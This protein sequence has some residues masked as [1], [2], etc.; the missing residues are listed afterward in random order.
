MRRCGH[1]IAR[2]DSSIVRSPTLFVRHVVF[3]EPHGEKFS[4]RDLDIRRS[5]DF[6][7]PSAFIKLA[8][9]CFRRACACADRA[10]VDF[11]GP[12][13]VICSR[14]GVSGVGRGM[15][16]GLCAHFS[17]PVRKVVIRARVCSPEFVPSS[18]D[19]P[20]FMLLTGPSPA[21]APHRDAAMNHDQG[22]IVCRGAAHDPSRLLSEALPSTRLQIQCFRLHCA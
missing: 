4:R 19:A 17:R 5:V 21:I 20:I 11:S 10:V 9:E 1:N 6:F 13:R 15:P 18:I 12:T 22:L 8:F 14:Q 2:H 7:L 16:F 3:F